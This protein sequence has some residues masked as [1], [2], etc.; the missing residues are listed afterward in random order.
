VLGLVVVAVL[1]LGGSMTRW[2]DWD[3]VQVLDASQPPLPS[4]RL[5]TWRPADPKPVAKPISV[6]SKPFASDDKGF[7]GSSARCSGAESAFAIGRTK[8]SLVVICGARAGR[9]EYRGVRLSDAAYL[10]AN[11]QTGSAR[12]FFAQKAGVVYAVSPKELTVTTGRNV[13]KREAMLEYR[14]V[15]H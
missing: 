8:A 2:A 5:L 7:L 3:S 1:A 4:Q 10:H 11:A 12:G 15:P 6:S 14:E 9:Y 13:I